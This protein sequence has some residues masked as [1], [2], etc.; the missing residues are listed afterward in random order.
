MELDKIY[1]VHVTPLERQFAIQ[2]FKP[3][4]DEWCDSDDVETRR[5]GHNLRNMLTRLEEQEPKEKIIYEMIVRQGEDQR[6]MK[7]RPFAIIRVSDRKSVIVKT[8]NS[9]RTGVGR[10]YYGDQK[11]TEDMLPVIKGTIV[12]KNLTDSQ[13]TALYIYLC[14]GLEPPANLKSLLLAEDD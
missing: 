9:H 6:K 5:Q 1:P 14:L 4:V 3:L 10:E 11:P 12:T 7:D 2:R 13:A 8:Y